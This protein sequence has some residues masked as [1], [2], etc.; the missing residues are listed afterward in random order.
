MSREAKR[1]AEALAMPPMPADKGSDRN[2]PIR[3]LHLE[4]NADDRDGATDFILK[5]KLGR[6]DSPVDERIENKTSTRLKP[7]LL[8]QAI[9]H[10]PLKPK[11]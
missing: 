2:G 4:D 1:S 8:N 6:L 9:E 7:M 3:V 11:W 5:H 10:P